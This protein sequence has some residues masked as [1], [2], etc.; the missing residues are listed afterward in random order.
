MDRPWLWIRLM[1]CDGHSQMLFLTQCSAVLASRHCE[2]CSTR[3]LAHAQSC[4]KRLQRYTHICSLLHVT[5]HTETRLG[6][7]QVT[8][9]VALHCHNNTHCPGHAQIVK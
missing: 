5:S 7:L 8:T 1:H 6:S 2:R 9:I 4:F 3:V